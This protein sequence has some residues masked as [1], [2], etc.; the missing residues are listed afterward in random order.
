MSVH[1]TTLLKVMQYVLIIKLIM[2][3]Y[4][5]HIKRRVNYILLKVSCSE[6]NVGGGRPRRCCCAPTA[7]NHSWLRQPGSVLQ[8]RASEFGLATSP[9]Y[10]KEVSRSNQKKSVKPHPD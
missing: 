4:L 10:W 1:V 6:I 3:F 2:F 8:R 9:T 5:Y 7:S